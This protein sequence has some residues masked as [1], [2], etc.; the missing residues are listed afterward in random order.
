MP[1]TNQPYLLYANPYAD[2]VRD[3]EMHSSIP[4]PLLCQT[5]SSLAFAMED[6]GYAACASPD[7]LSEL[8]ACFSPKEEAGGGL[9]EHAV[10]G[11][12]PPFVPFVPFLPF[13]GGAAV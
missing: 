1:G 11:E 10:A 8:L 2:C 6:M 5:A 3:L 7:V 9:D 13:G 4:A 12:R